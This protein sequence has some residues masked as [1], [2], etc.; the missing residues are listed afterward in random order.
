[1]YIILFIY[2]FV[3]NILIYSLS[4]VRNLCRSYL[5]MHNYRKLISCYEKSESTYTKFN[6]TDWLIDYITDW[7]DWPNERNG[8]IIFWAR[9]KHKCMNVKNV[10]KW[11]W[12]MSWYKTS[13][14]PRPGHVITPS[15]LWYKMGYKIW[16]KIWYKS[17]IKFTPGASV[18]SVKRTPWPN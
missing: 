6:G 7:L 3:P 12:E 2:I 1:M 10:V 8:C 5:I 15:Q 9:L 17:G 13:V 14:L 4:C 18:N 11:R 16:Y